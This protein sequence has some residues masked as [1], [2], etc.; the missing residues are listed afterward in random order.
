MRFT[1][2]FPKDFTDRAIEAIA[3][4]PEVCPA[5]HLPVQSGSDS[6]L[7][8]M[9]RG[10]S[11]S[12]YR[13][14]VTRL[15]AAVP[16]LSLSTDIIVGFCGESEEDF[17]RTVGLMEEM[18]FDSAYMFKYSE[19][20]GTAAHRKLADD[21]PQELKR[22]RLQEIIELQEQISLEVNQ[23]WLEKSVQVLVEGN[24]KRKTDEGT[25]NR[26]GRSG[27]GKVVVFPEQAEANS[28]RSV[29]VD[30]VTSH[31]LYGAAADA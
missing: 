2:P 22:E 26:F 25:A 6:Q 24:S 10:Y 3:D 17:R 20:S 28:M 19:R 15:R 14:L 12:Q 21:V 5:L 31:T 16:D 27:H 13:D 7:E 9:Q 30:R 4:L 29:L 18:R 1:S 8:R 23:Q 11:I